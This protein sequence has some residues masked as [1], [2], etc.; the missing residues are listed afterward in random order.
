LLTLFGY[1]CSLPFTGGVVDHQPLFRALRSAVNIVKNRG[2]G[3]GL[4]RRWH[5]F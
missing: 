5:P 4:N 1:S 3:A 2:A